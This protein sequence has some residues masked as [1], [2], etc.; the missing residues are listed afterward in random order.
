MNIV[1][2]V[3]CNSFYASCETI[4]K[5]DLSKKPI[6]V[7]SNNDGCVIARSS[8]AK[9]LGIKMGVPF[10]EIKQI[11]KKY[12]VHVFSSNYSLYGNI[13]SRVMGVLK[14]HCDRLEVYSIDEAF[15]GLD[16]FNK[17]NI[18]KKMIF[19]KKK[20]YQWTGIPVSV[21]IGPTKTLAKLANRIAKK[22]V[23]E[24]VYSLQDSNQITQVLNDLELETIWG[25][26]KGWAN[27]LKKIGINNALQLQRANPNHIKQHISVV[28][29]ICDSQDHSL[30]MLQME[31]VE[32]FRH[33][34]CILSPNLRCWTSRALAFFF[35]AVHK[36]NF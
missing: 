22:Y 32:Q 8:E 9:K 31:C 29:W 4:F 28:V 27:R 34:H 20:I 14:E 12:P 6:V 30:L 18:Y 23:N 19:M 36:Q 24:G 7:L 17:S 10:F 16:G 3:D 11:I 21:G 1:A 26:S 33:P 15:L 5:P 35:W 2:L 13:S 25:I